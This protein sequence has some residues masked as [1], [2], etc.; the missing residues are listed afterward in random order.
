MVQYLRE[1]L[2]GLTAPARLATWRLPTELDPLRLK[3]A[4]GSL[5]SVPVTKVDPDMSSEPFGPIPISPVTP[6]GPLM[7][8]CVPV[9]PSAAN[10]LA[11]P[12]SNV[13]AAHGAGLPARASMAVTAAASLQ[14]PD[15]RLACLRPQLRRPR[16]QMRD[17][18]QL[19]PRHVA[20]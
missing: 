13:S 11:A 9:R 15:S 20:S 12:R 16:P 1:I 19:R 2:R 3:A 10:R 6:E 8:I 5:T 14:H 7:V 4:V 17:G 18:Q